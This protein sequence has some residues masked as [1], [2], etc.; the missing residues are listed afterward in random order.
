MRIAASIVT[1]LRLPSA[2]V[3][4]ALCAPMISCKKGTRSSKLGSA[5]E[6]TSDLITLNGGV[7]DA[8]AE[9][10]N[11]LINVLS[12]SIA[13]GLL[14]NGALTGLGTDYPT[15]KKLATDSAYF[16]LLRIASVVDW[17]LKQA[18]EEALSQGCMPQDI[19]VGSGT[20]DKNYAAGLPERFQSAA[21][22][23]R[24]AESLLPISMNLPTIVQIDNMEK[25][26]AWPSQSTLSPAHRQAQISGTSTKLRYSRE[27]ISQNQDI[28]EKLR[29]MLAALTPVASTLTATIPPIGSGDPK[30]YAEFYLPP[31]SEFS[32]KDIN[33][34]NTWQLSRGI[35]TM[36]LPR[37][38]DVNVARITHI[39]YLESAD[40]A[41]EP[42]IKLQLFKDFK[43]PDELQVRIIF[44]ELDPNG[45]DQGTLPLNFTNYKN[46]FFVSFYP[47]LVIDPDDSKILRSLKT[48][49]NT[50]A[51]QFRIEARIH[52]ITLKLIRESKKD[53]TKQGIDSV[54]LKPRF[55]LKESDLS[56]RLHQVSGSPEESATLTR[57]GF[58]C[59]PATSDSK[60]SCYRDFGAFTDLHTYLV[61]GSGKLTTKL[62]RRTMSVINLLVKHNSRFLINWNMEAIEKAMDTEFAAIVSDFLERQDER[63]RDIRSRL[64]QT[65]YTEP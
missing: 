22:A 19:S 65:F 2:C 50:V 45:A 27:M 63:R 32:A 25:P 37:E 62:A 17:E 53:P 41:R 54:L 12:N 33:D 56:F 1:S 64:E 36:A 16:Q 31:L 13:D 49:I 38:V 26:Q 58:I 35:K 52:Q 30:I 34:V 24:R 23:L 20:F 29:A 57:V 44:G 28:K 21:A 14:A 59:E 40:D 6:N 48:D 61:E 10:R 60:Q 9:C 51:N 8:P 43:K 5:L 39:G 11:T 42:L 47:N 46:A 7:V 4:V 55:A 18:V 3:A 15:G